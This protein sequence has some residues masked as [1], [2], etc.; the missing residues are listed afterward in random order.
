MIV[1]RTQGLSRTADDTAWRCLARRGM[2]HSE[3][4]SFDYLWLAPGVLRDGRGRE[5]T[6]EAWFVLG[7][8]GEFLDATGGWDPLRAGDLVLWPGGTG[9]WLRGGPTRP[10]ELLALSMLPAA[11]TALLPARSPVTVSR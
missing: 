5:G 1:S 4:E 3:C 6:E 7:G 2:L 10:L 8:E 11:V 9:G